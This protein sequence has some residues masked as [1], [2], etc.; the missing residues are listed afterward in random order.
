M[1]DDSPCGEG[2]VQS[3]EH[4]EQAQP[5]EMFSSLIYLQELSKV[6]VHNRDWSSDPAGDHQ[7][8]F[9]EIIYWT[10]KMQ[11]H[12]KASKWFHQLIKLQYTTIRLCVYVKNVKYEIIQELYTAVQKLGQFNSFL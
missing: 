2:S 11:F 10:D 3:S 12:H 4:P 1:W 8:L 7:K 5:A 6:R 9:L